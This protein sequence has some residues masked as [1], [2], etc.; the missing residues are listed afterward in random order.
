MFKNYFKI[1]LRN[2][3]KQKLYSFI[4]IFGLA[5]GL[6][7]CLLVFLFVNDELSFDQFHTDKDDIYRLYRQPLVADTPYDIDTFTPLPTG[8]AMVNDIPEVESFTRLTPF[9]NL[10]IRNNGE[11]FDQDGFAFA[12]PYVFD[13]FNLPFKYG[14]SENA[15]TNPNSIVI[16]EE[17]AEK[18]FENGNPVGN[19]LSI[20]INEVFYDFKV[21]GVL[22]PIPGNSSLQFELLIPT[23]AVINNFEQYSRVENSWRG[24]RTYTFVQL[25]EDSDLDLVQE[26]LPGFINTY[27]GDTFDEMRE[28]GRLS[29]SGPPMIYNL[30]PL[31][32]IHLN[33]DIPGGFIAP[34]NP[35]YSY[36]LAGI[37]LAVLLIACF[38][39]MILSIGRSTKRFKEVGLRKVVGA[40]RKQ[41][42][43][44]FW[45]EA[46]LITLIAFLLGLFLAELLLPVFNDLANKELSLS[47][48]LTNTNV[49]A[50]LGVIFI[51]TGLI[52]GSYP[53]LVL[54]G[55]K[56]VQSLKNGLKGQGSNS[57]TKSLVVA[58]FGFS[59]FLITATFIMSNQLSYMQEKNL[60]FSGEQVVVV[61]TTGLDGERT[62]QLFRNNLETETDIISMSGANS[63]L[64]FGLWR[65][66]YLFNEEVTVSSV[67]RV[68]PGYLETLQMNL[69][70]GR[71][72]D[73]LLSSDSTS[74]IIVNQAFM[75]QHG[76]E[77]DYVG[78]NFHL[79]WSWMVEPTIIGVVE[80]F[81]FQS[82]ISEVEPVMIYVNPRDPIL[83]LVIRI[84]PDDMGASIAKIENTW[85]QITN[86]IPFS[87]SF[88]D[89]NMASLYE[90]EQR[91]SKILSYSS[92]LAILIACLGLFGLAGIISLQ[93]QKEIGIRKVLGATTQ[94]I[95]L[96]LTS[97]ITKLVILSILISSPVAWYVMSKWLEGFA[98]RIDISPWVFITSG[99]IS[100]MIALLT[101]SYQ[102]IKAA[103][104]DPVQ[105]LKTE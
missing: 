71:D 55:F 99:I 98:Y 51:L 43:A 84:K 67:L 53:A 65:R 3:L 2:L 96:M 63:S 19:Y 1:A 9:G 37:A 89:D 46:I 41:L 70:A 23:Q 75:Q 104:K 86:E 29:S 10:V 17:I 22:E 73:P 78:Q 20:R 54:S 8:Q 85:N 24:T 76:L 25:R 100:L 33:P 101:V 39:F 34:S 77:L 61:P 4:N 72:F 87:Y 82:L 49:I 93:R 105:N 102:S 15:L 95:T 62:L 68:D 5:V 66:G 60:G 31:L 83:N 92:F 14:S 40:S 74:S 52:A 64:S 79:N 26:K 13:M 81:N 50:G 97:G 69:I 94:G 16:S 7:F 88:L 80:D 36:V 48:S 103:I 6:T 18:Y 47:S 38:N 27:M 57:F 21:D 12:D 91:W 44:Q 56:P 28:S 11:V 32:D 30:Q 59:I 45:G 35:I 58:Q 42:M 90:N